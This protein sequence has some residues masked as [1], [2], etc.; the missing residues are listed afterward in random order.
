MTESNKPASAPAHDA[1]T[2]PDLDFIPWSPQENIR[3]FGDYE[4]IGEVARGGMGVVYKARQTSLNRFVAVK[5]ILASRLAD[6][7][8]IWR[9]HVE[10]EAAARLQHPNIVGVHEVG[11]HEGQHYFSMDYVDGKSLSELLSEGPLP[12]SLAASYTQRLAMAMQY[13]HDRGVLHRDLKPS[14]VIIDAEGTPRITDFGLAKIESDVDDFTKTGSI[15]GTVHYMAPEQAAGRSDSIGVR[16][17]VYALGAMLYEMATGRPPFKGATLP[18]TLKQVTEEAPV[19][20]RKLNP[21]IPTELEMIVMKCLEKSPVRRYASASELASDLERFLT[22]QPIQARSV[23]W[24]QRTETWLGKHPWIVSCMLTLGLLV[25]LFV[26]YG[27]W[28]KSQFTLWKESPHI[29]PGLPSAFESRLAQWMGWSQAVVFLVFAL[30]LLFQKHCRGATWTDFFLHQRKFLAAEE[31]PVSPLFRRIFAGIGL[32]A[33]VLGLYL[34]S[35]V[36]CARVWEITINGTLA[37]MIPSLIFLGIASLCMVS[38]NRRLNLYGAP[39]VGDEP[40]PDII[41]Q[42]ILERATPSAMALYHTMR[43]ELTF[44]E[45]RATVQRW[46]SQMKAVDPEPFEKPISHAIPTRTLVLGSLV[47]ALCLVA[48]AYTFPFASPTWWLLSALCA[49]I[50][51]LGGPFCLESKTLKGKILAVLPGAVAFV[52]LLG[53]AKP[54]GYESVSFAGFITGL[55]AIVVMLSLVAHFG[56]KHPR[57]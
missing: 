16:S 54:L 46:G 48:I 32:V 53:S 19:S 38:R 8:A 33:T 51:A 37:I 30:W 6:E 49:V 18:A 15:L 44:S 1:G 13:A 45:C 23:S 14:N 11:E 20:M 22:K 27:M 50:T 12:T 3:Y 36:I 10:A 34:T 28:Q 39:I 21:G 52:A 40:M 7:A 5:M 55:T 17:D 35:Q 31:K 4:I 9:F 57:N 2:L 56:K 29:Y 41:R 24:F 47:V 25:L 26:T 43:P 42:E